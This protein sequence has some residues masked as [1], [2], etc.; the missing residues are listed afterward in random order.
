[1][2]QSLSYNGNQDSAARRSTR[3]AT[4]VLVEI[5]GESFVYAGQTLMV[6]AHGA[7]VKIAAP[8]KAGDQVVIYVHNSG[9]SGRARV[10]F[11]DG[12]S[13]EFGVELEQPENIWGVTLPPEDWQNESQPARD[14][15]SLSGR[16]GSS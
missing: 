5:Q 9:K 11:V 3:I 8:L 7:L 2:G 1:M 16:A 13:S 4:D 14:S 15:S 12:K 6:N 10:V